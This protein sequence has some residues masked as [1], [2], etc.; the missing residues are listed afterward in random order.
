MR[1]LLAYF[2]A[3]LLSPL[4][5]V[6]ITIGTMWV[7]S[8]WLRRRTYLPGPHPLLEEFSPR[9]AVRWWYAVHDEL[10]QFG[11]SIVLIRSLLGSITALAVAAFICNRLA[12]PHRWPL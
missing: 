6:C 4:L 12:V 8:P 3:N 5:A 10:S 7:L 1:T 9:P 2:L 11:D